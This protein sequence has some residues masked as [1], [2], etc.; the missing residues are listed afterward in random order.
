MNQCAVPQDRQE[1]LLMW[2]AAIS[3]FTDTMTFKVASQDVERHPFTRQK[4]D[5]E[6][7]AWIDIGAQLSRKKVF[8]YFLEI[9]RLLALFRGFFWE[10][11]VTEVTWWEYANFDYVLEVHICCGNGE[12]GGKSY[13][14]GPVIFRPKG[15]GSPRPRMIALMAETL[16]HS[17]GLTV[18][19]KEVPPAPTDANVSSLDDASEGA[20]HEQRT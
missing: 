13:F 10:P 17:W 19:V 2:S 15:Q 1:G 3:E 7:Y 8:G 5:A 4:G 9:H 6:I 11:A 16:A 12:G 14:L 18:A 20:N